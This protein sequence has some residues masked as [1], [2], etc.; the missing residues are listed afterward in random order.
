MEIL[1]LSNS[2]AVRGPMAEAL[3]K[4][5]LGA[6]HSVRSCG[7]SAAPVHPL[8]VQAMRELGLDIAGHQAKS[9]RDIDTLE[10]EMT[11]NLCFGEPGPIIPG[12]IRRL[13][14]PTPDPLKGPGDP[15]STLQRLRQ[16]RDRLDLKVAALAAE[17]KSAVAV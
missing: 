15:E 8:A 3:L 12:R 9:R 13:D 1:V 7:H 10:V 11:L 17:L 2:N 6:A 4:R 5:A 14:W 16:A